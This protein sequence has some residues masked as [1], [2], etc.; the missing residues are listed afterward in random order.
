MGQVEDLEDDEQEDAPAKAENAGPLGWLMRR[1]SYLG[2][3][4]GLI[5]RRCVFQCL[6]A[7]CVKLDESA[8]V[9]NLPRI[10]SPLF[11]ITT[12]REVGYEASQLEELATEVLAL[13]EKT[14]GANTFTAADNG[15]RT[16]MDE[17][18]R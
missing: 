5:K 13:V 18:K 6:A 12:H 1:L 4:N 9:A 3:T 8:I 11:R 16:H 2:R 7:L 10:V 14:V 15:V 17:N